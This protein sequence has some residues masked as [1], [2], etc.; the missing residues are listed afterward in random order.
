M[1][2]R[3]FSS[4]RENLAALD[5]LL[6][7][8]VLSLFFLGVACIYSAGSG[9]PQGGGYAYRQI[10][11]FCVSAGA[12]MAALMVGY[13]K[14]M[15]FTYPIYFITLLLLVITMFAAP[16][17]K[18]AQR[19]IS[20]GF[21]GFQPSEFGK[22]AIVL[23]MAK[24]LNRYPPLNWKTFLGGLL[25]GSPALLMVLKQPDL[26]SAL[27]YAAII[28][29]ALFVAGSPMK[30]I[31]SFMGLGLAACP[32]LWSFLKEYQKLRLLV[33]LDP[34]RDPLGAGYNV[35]QSRIAVGSGSFWG[36]GFLQG[37]QSK[38]RFLPEPHTDFIFS[39]Y[40]EEFGFLGSSLILAV[41]GLIFTRMILLGM[42]SHEIRAKILVAGITVWIWFQT[43]EGIGMT[44]G[45]M[46][47]TGLPL[48]FLSYGGSSVLSVSIALGLLG[49]VALESVKPYK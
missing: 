29:A 26:G 41:F 11:W 48:P 28:M 42:K 2:A 40:A 7:C 9:G 35:I 37:L 22:I 23:V 25:V 19:M 47:V 34:T 10:F 14:L 38:L 3:G 20:L 27:V 6:L 1:N 5:K 8:G 46:P 33:F 24:F 49:S 43:F 31:M 17:V 4:L 15:D 18:G 32:V 30:Y 44:M 13:R 39:V 36:K 21:I 12:F 16:N 45:L